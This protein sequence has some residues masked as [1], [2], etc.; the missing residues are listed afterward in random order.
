[1]RA[2]IQR[3][4]RAKVSVEEKIHSEIKAGI[5]ILLG[6]DIDDTNEDLEWLAGKIS[7][8]RIFDDEEGVMNK[9]ITQVSGE[10]MLIS[11]FTL[12]AQ[13]KKG[14]R[15]SYVRAARPDKAMPM[16]EEMCDKL[17]KLTQR[18]VKTGVF[19]EKM[20]IELINDG[21]VTIVIDSKN[22]E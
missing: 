13:T 7:K 21:P 16:Y 3:V 14:N 10:I 17:M 20:Q 4:K 15:P 6:V 9:D 12:L 2:V 5:M 11:Q 22:K 18:P 19:G 1:M 8:L